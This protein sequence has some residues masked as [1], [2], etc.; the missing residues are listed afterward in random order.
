MAELS[1]AEIAAVFGV[2]PKTVRQWTRMGCPIVHPGGRG[3]PSV[4]ET[5]QVFRWREEQARMAASGDLDAMD[6]EEAKRRKL[7]A[8]AATAELNLAISQ[9]HVIAVDLIEREVGAALSAC[10]SRLMSVGAKV[11]PQLDL[12]ETAAA[13][14]EIIDD[15][16]NEALDEIS[17]PMFAFEIGDADEEQGN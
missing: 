14:K 5:A 9:G 10:R 12:A 17:G 4:Y 16:I 11:A 3:L 7:A 13:R 1:Q 8:E 2:T 6:Y 15:A